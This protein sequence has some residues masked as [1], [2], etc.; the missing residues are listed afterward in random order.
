MSTWTITGL[1]FGFNYYFKKI[2]SIGKQQ[3]IAT[4]AIIKSKFTSKY[5]TFKMKSYYFAM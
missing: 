1:V 2:W 5:K 4:A 3:K